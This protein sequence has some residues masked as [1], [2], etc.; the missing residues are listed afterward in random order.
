MRTLLICPFLFLTNPPLLFILTRD[1][2]TP[3]PASALFFSLLLRS[4]V[5]QCYC[6]PSFLSII[7][8]F[9][10]NLFQFLP[11]C[12]LIVLAPLLAT[13]TYDQDPLWLTDESEMQCV[14]IDLPQIVLI[15]FSPPPIFFFDIRSPSS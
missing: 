10:I 14:R 1:D 13:S 15:F 2:V 12:L 7:R 11:P 5:C 3:F 8:V 6:D 4:T 9:P